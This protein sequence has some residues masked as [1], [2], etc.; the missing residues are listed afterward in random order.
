MPSA[1]RYFFGN[2]SGTWV[3]SRT[4]QVTWCL[5]GLVVGWIGTSR[6]HAAWTR[7]GRRKS[8]RHR[9]PP[10]AS[11]ASHQPRSARDA[12]D[13]LEHGGVVAGSGRVQEG[14]RAAERDPARGGG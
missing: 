9:R 2:T 7:A 11:L 14:P 13:A 3:R 8:E 5:V 1:R 12:A 6:R 4:Y 10:L